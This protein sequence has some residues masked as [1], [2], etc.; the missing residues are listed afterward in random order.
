M[1]NCNMYLRGRRYSD[2]LL[3]LQLVLHL[4]MYTEKAEFRTQ[5]FQTHVSTQSETNFL[6]AT[7]EFYRSQNKLFVSYF[8]PV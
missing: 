6:R 4:H 1:C 2:D 7:G 3:Y 5:I 8:L